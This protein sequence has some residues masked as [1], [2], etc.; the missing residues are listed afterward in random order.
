M[1]ITNLLLFE[2]L[3]ILFP[4]ILQSPI[5][6]NKEYMIKASMIEKF[7][8]FTEWEN[9]SIGEYFVIEVLGEDPFKG[10]L[11]KMALGIKIM[12]KPVRISYIQ[13]Y[14]S[15]KG[16]QIL[17]ISS[18][19]KYKLDDIVKYLENNNILIIGDSPNFCKKGVHFNFY[20]KNNQTIHFEINLKALIKARLKID[21]Q[22]LSIG[23]I[24]N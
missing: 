20:I 8:R 21:M 5:G 14:H 12:N 17:F 7:T 6:N 24:I 23:K 19:E 18:S 11:E 16:C 10:E 3:S 1:Y 13:D 2:I 22:L 4:S 9:N 15:V